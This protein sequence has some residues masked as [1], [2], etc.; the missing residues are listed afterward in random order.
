MPTKACVPYLHQVFGHQVVYRVPEFQRLYSWN[1][2]DQWTPLWADVTEMAQQLLSGAQDVLPHFMGAMV[3]QPMDSGQVR[4]IDGQQRLTTLQIMI[5]ALQTYFVQYGC[6]HL[7]LHPFTR[8]N[9]DTFKIDHS[10]QTDA[11]V[12]TSII[13]GHRFDGD[14][15]IK[16]AYEFFSLKARDWIDSDGPNRRPERC[17]S[18]AT[19][20]SSRIQ[21]AWISIDTSERP[22]DIFE[23]LNGR[24]RALRQSDLIR[25]LIMYEAEEAGDLEQIFRIWRY[26]DD[27]P[28]WTKIEGHNCRVD[29]FMHAWVTVKRHTWCV[30]PRIAASFRA[31]FDEERKKFESVAV[32]RVA[33]STRLAGRQYRAIHT[34]EYMEL[35]R[36]RVLAPGELVMP[37]LL[38]LYIELNDVMLRG[39]CIHL[40]ESSL[41]RMFLIPFG[42]NWRPGVGF[43]TSLMTLDQN[44]S[45]FGSL[46]N[47]LRRDPR[48]NDPFFREWIVDLSHHRVRGTIGQRQM[49]MVEI[50]KNMRGRERHE[51]FDSDVVL[52]DIMP[53]D[54]QKLG[55]W[56]RHLYDV[57]AALSIGNLTLVP[58]NII[59]RLRGRCWSEQRAV[60]GTC[61]ELLLNRDLLNN[62]PHEAD[63]NPETITARAQRLTELIIGIWPSSEKFREGL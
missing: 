51:R 37:Y 6:E 58:R 31:Y 24:A 15:P 8:N 13:V 19:A 57:D 30:E 12:F 53:R 18:L 48:L 62:V 16:A 34:D 41:V 5:A 29:S 11:R 22:H 2:D 20:I 39:Q 49:I 50:E 1:R 3:V 36:L 27:D 55:D 9:D 28:W 23:V 56:P 4:V 63:W 44:D 47:K 40:L 21:F 17:A 10:N 45:H 38:F 42:N 43:F 46:F 60:L 32:R 54:I 14:H 61:S 35:D 33:E 52:H 7:R 59:Q 25:N 26:F